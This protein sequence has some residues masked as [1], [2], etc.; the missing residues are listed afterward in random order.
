MTHED[1]V[2]IKKDKDGFSLMNAQ[3]TSHGSIKCCGWKTLRGF[4]KV[5]KQQN[6]LLTKH[7]TR[8]KFEIILPMPG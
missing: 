8:V 5:L 3:L 6:K 1:K 7:N 2:Q 4:I